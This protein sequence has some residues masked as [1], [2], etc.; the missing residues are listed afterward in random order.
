MISFTRARVCVCV[1]AFVEP[2][3]WNTT[4]KLY[5]SAKLPVGFGDLQYLPNN[6]CWY[7]NMTRWPL[8]VK[9]MAETVISFILSQ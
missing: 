1:L 4:T 6:D 5:P 3:E 8:I 9:H 2:C 7:M